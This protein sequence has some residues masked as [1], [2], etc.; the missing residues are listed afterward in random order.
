MPL[1]PW[2]SKGKTP[3]TARDESSRPP[4][5]CFFWPGPQAYATIWWKPCTKSKCIESVYPGPQ[6]TA[7]A[8]SGIRAI[9]GAGRIEPLRCG[10]P[11]R[12][13]ATVNVQ[14]ASCGWL[15]KATVDGRSSGD[16]NSTCTVS[17]SGNR[18]SKAARQRA[19][20]HMPWAMA[21][22]K[23]KRRATRGLR[24]IGLTS[25]ETAA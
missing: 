17:A 24:W 22:R 16:L 2:T 13:P 5:S 8:P 3:P 14:R 23:P 18:P 15:A 11:E 12:A 6:V 4:G 20:S 7:P 10:R 9:H 21:R 25:P 19:F 1:R